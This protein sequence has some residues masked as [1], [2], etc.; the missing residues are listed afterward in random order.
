[1]DIKNIPKLSE[2]QISTEF[3][4]Q[5]NASSPD[6]SD[7]TGIDNIKDSAETYSTD[8]FSAVVG[9]SSSYSPSMSLEDL[10]NDVGNFLTDQ[11]PMNLQDSVGGVF[12]FMMQYQK[13]MNAENRQDRQIQRTFGQR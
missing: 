10:M 8:S 4:D 13:M 1:M 5:T 12:A 9:K 3:A 6:G 2:P 11:G 7:A